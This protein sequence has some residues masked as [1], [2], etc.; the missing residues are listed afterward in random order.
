MARTQTWDMTFLVRQAEHDPALP[1]RV[2]CIAT[3][4][5]TDPRTHPIW[6]A[7]KFGEADLEWPIP[8]VPEPA[9]W[10]ERDLGAG[11]MDFMALPSSD[12]VAYEVRALDRT[13]CLVVRVDRVDVSF[14]MG[15]RYNNVHIGGFQR[16]VAITYDARGIGYEQSIRRA[17]FEAFDQRQCE[18]DAD[19]RE[20]S[21]LDAELERER[22]D[23]QEL[24][25]E[26]REQAE[27]EAVVALDQLVLAI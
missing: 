12:L 6:L 5:D 27:R 14:S 20:A 1:T 24:L 18:F 16:W 21:K 17:V 19:R 22:E 26:A 25:N 23:E 8:G 7:A 3:S 9:G 4:C 2:V 11:Y 13:I 15:T 10:R